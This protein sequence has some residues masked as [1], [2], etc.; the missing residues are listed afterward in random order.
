MKFFKY[1]QF[2]V[3]II[4]LLCTITQFLGFTFLFYN[5]WGALASY[6][7]SIGCIGFNLLIFL[8]HFIISKIPIQNKINKITKNICIIN[9]CINFCYFISIIIGVFFLLEFDANGSTI[10]GY[11]STPFV[12]ILLNIIF[13]YFYFFKKK[14]VK[15]RKF[16]YYILLII[17]I[18]MSLYYIYKIYINFFLDY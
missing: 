4:F 18:I 8:Y 16:F 11:Y 3:Y 10:K 6:V 9:I 5:D 14:Y 12:Y 2:L 7:M 13:L 17:S 15:I 1:T